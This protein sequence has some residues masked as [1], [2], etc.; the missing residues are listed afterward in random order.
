MYVIVSQIRKKSSAQDI[1]ASSTA[2]GMIGIVFLV[3][4]LGSL[5]L[6]DIT[7]IKRDVGVMIGNL[8][9]YFGP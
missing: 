1:R 5:V 6:L 9:E 2:V 4:T 7:S 3:V 8:R